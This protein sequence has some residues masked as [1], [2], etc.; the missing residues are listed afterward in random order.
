[1]QLA[2]IPVFD[3]KSDQAKGISDLFVLVLAIGFAII[4][5]VMVLVIFAI[6]K[7][8]QRDNDKSEPQQI[9]GNRKWE[10]GWTAAPAVL[11]AV[12]FIP[13]FIVMNTSDPGV[14][15]DQAQGQP[16]LEIIGHQFWWE[17]R[18]PKSGVVT[19]NDLHLPV[20]QKI[21]TRV[22]SAD[23]IHDFWVPE[24]GRKMD[25]IPGKPNYMWLVSDQTGLFN[26]ACAEYCGASHAWMLIRVQVQPAADFEAWLQA[27]KQVPAPPPAGSQAEKGKQLFDQYSCS[28]CH[29][30][31]GT[32]ANG[33]VGPNLTHV[34]SRPILGSGILQ[35]SPENLSRWVKD[36]PS[37]KPGAKMPSYQ[38]LRDDELQALVAYLEGLK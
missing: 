29:S 28:T 26:G 7:F 32:N 20:G 30:I 31:A 33:Q 21:L 34:A 25:A 36:A 10:I 11:L 4:L 22:D 37:V 27:Q 9:H 2:Q 38:Q 14:P 3:P 8:H 6:V 19:A 1:M 35:N 23:V 17:Y 15:S 16:E 12:L 24:L 18:F 13:T 5:L